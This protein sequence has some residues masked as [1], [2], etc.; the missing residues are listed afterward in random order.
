M[1]L[2]PNSN[3]NLAQEVRIAK[4]HIKRPNYPYP[5][6]LGLN[7]SKKVGSIVY[8]LLD[9]LRCKRKDN[10]KKTLSFVV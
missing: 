2:E 1:D 7:N 4:D 5:T 3:Q 6:D 10:E 9:M 8:H